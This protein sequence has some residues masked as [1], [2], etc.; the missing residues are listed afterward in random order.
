MPTPEERK[1][2]ESVKK[3]N[4]LELLA[5]RMKNTIIELR[6]ELKRLNE[7]Y[8]SSK[9]QMRR[10]VEA[11]EGLEKIS[12]KMIQSLRKDLETVSKR[13]E[14]IES[15]DWNKSKKDLERAVLEQQRR[16]QTQQRNIQMLARNDVSLKNNV[17]KAFEDQRKL[18]T[19]I[20][21]NF[22]I[23]TGLVKALKKKKSELEAAEAMTEISRTGEPESDGSSSS[24]GNKKRKGMR[25]LKL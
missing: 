15:T 25:T 22:E 3:L 21:K 24:S 17:K 14:K 9:I 23:L 8:I 6:K 7:R 4:E 2:R 16:I 5:E 13:L 20:A 18:N 11:V 10:R 1:E 19:T 12:D